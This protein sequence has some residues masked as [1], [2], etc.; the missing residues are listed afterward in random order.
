MRLNWKKL[1]LYLIITGFVLLLIGLI[2]R[3]RQRAAIPAGKP[4]ISDITVENSF[5]ETDLS[6]QA[7]APKNKYAL[8]S[9]EGGS[10]IYKIS[11]IGGME[12]IVDANAVV[13][14]ISINKSE[15]AALVGTTK[16]NTPS[17][18]KLDLTNDKLSPFRN[19]IAADWSGG[20]NII[21]LTTNNEVVT[22]A[23][24][25]GKSTPIGK[26]DQ[27][28]KNSLVTLESEGN[29][30]LIGITDNSVDLPLAEYWAVTNGTLKKLPQTGIVQSTLTPDGQYAL[31]Y[32]LNSDVEFYKL[33][34]GETGKIDV[35]KNPLPIAGVAQQK[36]VNITAKQTNKGQTWTLAWYDIGGEKKSQTVTAPTTWLPHTFYVNGNNI[37]AF[38]SGFIYVNDL[39]K[40]FKP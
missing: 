36:N 25:L 38:G 20:D 33:L 6:P 12:K 30:S 29:S 22:I 32:T 16:E 3:S 14:H 34:S 21:A 23:V 37:F 15:T 31:V 26:L 17:W 11:V 18:Y 13:T 2:V 40:V 9:L 10:I 28:T 19:I 35:S 24:N 7:L 39:T 8:A 5:A 4:S 27:L 1:G